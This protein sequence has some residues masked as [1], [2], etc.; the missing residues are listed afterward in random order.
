MADDF[1]EPTLPGD[2]RC[3]A[4][5]AP[6]SELAACDS[7]VEEYERTGKFEKARELK[8]GVKKAREK[9]D[10]ARAIQRGDAPLDFSRPTAAMAADAA[11]R[12]IDLQDPR[13][14]TMLRDLQGERREGR[15]L[16]S[17]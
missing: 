11:K 6:E 10:R 1:S 12:G 9:L 5:P 4:N 8:E 15:G 17:L 16:G 3:S 7:L 14:Q 13:V 2:G